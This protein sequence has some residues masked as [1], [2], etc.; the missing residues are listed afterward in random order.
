M[1]EVAKKE[2][3]APTV[4]LRYFLQQGH[5]LCLRLQP[6]RGF[7]G[8]LRVGA[9]AGKNIAVRAGRHISCHVGQS[10]RCPEMDGGA[11]A[12]DQQRI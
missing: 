9:G 12:T 11:L 6:R 10:S 1:S 3:L 2:V 5:S 4:C 8:A 7:Q